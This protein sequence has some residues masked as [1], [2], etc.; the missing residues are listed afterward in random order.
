ML[1]S[2]EGTSNRQPVASESDGHG[3]REPLRFL[4]FVAEGKPVPLNWK[5]ESH[6]QTGALSMIPYLCVIVCACT[7][8]LK[9]H[10][11][12]KFK[13][14]NMVPFLDG[15]LQGN[16]KLI[17]SEVLKMKSQNL[18]DRRTWQLRDGKRRQVPR[19]IRIELM[20][21]GGGGI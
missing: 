7:Q 16:S 5:G 10:V 18:L 20:G 1:V 19:N 4:P 2:S 8:N 9:H 12:S 11:E 13:Q 14:H 17:A 3:R 6:R 21:S 15:E